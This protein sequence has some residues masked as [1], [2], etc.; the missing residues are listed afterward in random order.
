MRRGIIGWLLRIGTIRLEGTED[1]GMTIELRA[2]S[3]PKV[4]QN[5]LLEVQCHTTDKAFARAL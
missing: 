4:V 5:F 1:A 3:N 2:V